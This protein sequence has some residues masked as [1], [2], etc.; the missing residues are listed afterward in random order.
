MTRHPFF[1]L[2]ESFEPG[3]FL[4]SAHRTRPRHPRQRSRQRMSN[5]ARATLAAEFG[6]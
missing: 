3:E 1:V 5:A 4:S 2:P 6:V